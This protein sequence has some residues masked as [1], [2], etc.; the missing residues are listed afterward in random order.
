MV[1]SKKLSAD[2]PDGGDDERSLKGRGELAKGSAESTEALVLAFAEAKERGEEVDAVSFALRYPEAGDSLLK[3]LRTLESVESLFLEHPAALA[4]ALPSRVGD[5]IVLGEL[6]RGG[7]G[8]VLRVRKASDGPGGEVRALKLL[9]DS[10]QHQPRAMERFRREGEALERVQHPGVVRLHESGVDGGRP[11]L[12]MELVEGRSLAALLAK[13]RREG[14]EQAELPGE[15]P[16][17]IRVA[18]LV[19]RI[20]RSVSAAHAEGVLHRDLNPKNILLDHAEQPVV[21]DFGLVHADGSDTLTVTGDVVGTPAYMSPEQAL[22]TRVDGRADVFGL[23]ALLFELMTMRP[24]R[25]S[26]D[27]FAILREAGLQPVGDARR[28][29]PDLDRTLARIIRRATA[30]RADWRYQSPGDLAFD[31]EAFVDGRPLSVERPGV[32]Q[33][34]IEV[35]LCHRQTVLACGAILMLALVVGV[36]A[37]GGGFRSKTVSPE[38]IASETGRMLV[39]WLDGD[40]ERAYSA[41]EFLHSATP[42]DRMLPFYDAMVAG[43]L[44]SHSDDPMVQALIDGELHRLGGRPTEA[45]KMYDIAWKFEPGTALLP[46]LSGMAKLDAGLFKDSAEA[47]EAVVLQLFASKRIHILL[48]QAFEGIGDRPLDVVLALETAKVNDPS[49]ASIAFELARAY[50]V[51][52]ENDKARRE[53]QRAL[54][55]DSSWVEECLRERLERLGAGQEYEM[56]AALEQL[57]GN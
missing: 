44:L 42:T 25:Q 48:S 36:F 13:A 35:W 56:A 47:F 52:G 37:A 5:Y 11:Y 1:F 54:R 53:A 27:T 4:P 57:F 22:G 46:V 12:V 32:A 20:A 23:G 41:L 17:A 19:A 28:F 7:M 14:Q 43:A 45:I 33:R 9:H 26:D 55:L 10:L 49:D 30:F 21:V 6:G 50:L 38:E 8:R 16:Y 51:A 29:V 18:R 39:A 3:A 24:P 2:G 40:R 34:A 31:L 15:G